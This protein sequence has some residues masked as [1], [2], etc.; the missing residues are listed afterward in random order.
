MRSHIVIAGCASTLLLTALGAASISGPNAIGAPTR[1]ASASE[2]PLLLDPSGVSVAAYTGWAAWSRTDRTTGQYALVTRSPGGVISLPAVAESPVPF[3]VELGPTPDS[4]VAAVYS[5][6]ADSSAHAGC[7]LALLQLG[8][9]TTAE[10]TL[11]PPGGGSD[12]EPAIWNERLVFLRRDPSGG[13]RRPD[14]LFSWK[15]GSARV[16][17]LTLPNSRGHRRAGWPSGL[18]GLVTGL[19]FNGRQVA[20]VTSNLVGTF[21]ETTLW[22]E[23][24]AGPPELIDQETGGAGNVCPPEFVSPALAGQWLYAYLHACDPSANPR[25]DRLT[26]YRR[27]EVQRARYTF[28]HAGDEPISSVIPDGGAVEWDAEGIQRLA[29][30][31]WQRIAPPVPQT[32]CS[33]SDPFC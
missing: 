9:P 7:H 24:L 11:A 31:S 10:R 23:P 1:A 5:R 12:H 32:F 27:G 6:C 2:K 13:S 26:R 4:G 14:R 30:V 28:V 15:I 21:G 18:T 19:S 25:L 16:Q 20:Y 22:L 17:T 8:A 33:R 29:R 3:D